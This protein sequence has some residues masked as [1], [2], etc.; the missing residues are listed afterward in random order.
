MIN[1]VSFQ[2]LKDAYREL[3]SCSKHFLGQT[4]YLMEVYAKLRN[5][6]GEIAAELGKRVI[7]LDLRE[8]KP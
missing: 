4:G 3:D 1:N 2:G 5:T 6:Q 7:A 8:P